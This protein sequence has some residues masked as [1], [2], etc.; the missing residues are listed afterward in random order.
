MLH[1]RHLQELDFLSGE[2]L[3]KI[4]GIILRF[5]RFEQKTYHKWYLVNG[6]LMMSVNDLLLIY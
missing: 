2:I 3:G 5:G 4:M 6:I 1:V